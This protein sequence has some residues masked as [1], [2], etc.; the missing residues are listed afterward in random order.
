[1]DREGELRRAGW[2]LVGSATRAHPGWIALSVVTSLIWTGTK[3]T[4]PLLT[5]G[6]IDNGII[7]GD[8]GELTKYVALIIAVGSF[9]AIISALRRTAT[10]RLS[11]RVETELRH[12]LFA[13]LQRLHFAF[14][15]RA[16]T[17]QLMARANSDILQ[18]REFV[19]T[20]PFAAMSIMLILAIAGI[21]FATSV[22]LALLALCSLPVLNVVAMRFSRRMGPISF[23]L[24]QE[25]ADLSAVVEESLS[26]I[27]VV[28]GFGAEQL[29]VER[30]ETEA[31]SVREQALAASR[32]RAGLMP[33]I[34]FIPAI[35]L[36]MVLWYGGNLVL[37]GDL[38]LGTLVAFNTYILMSAWPLRMTGMIIV[39]ASRSATAAGRIQELLSTDPRIADPAKGR[40]VA[41]P[42]GGGEVRFDDVTFSY[43]DGAAVLDGLDLH[44][45]AGEAVALVGPTAS[46][47]STVARLVPRFY[48]A[49]GG[50][51]LLDGVD[52]RKLRLRD[53]RR[54]VGI[55]FE[56]TFL[57]SDTVRANIAFAD[58][59]AP[60]EAIERAAALAGAADFVEELPDGY[61]TLIGE[62]GFSLSGGQRQ[63]IA[64]ARAVLADPR[65]LIL[66]DATSAVDPTKEHEIRGA[67][68]EVMAGRTTIIIAHRPAT[69]ALADRVVLIDHGRV[70]A[71]GTH[72]D[73]V[74]TSAKYRDVLAHSDV[75]VLHRDEVTS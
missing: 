53:L 18:V 39:M 67:L 48:D 38:R 74:A 68:R 51:V 23:T 1:V 56:D 13:H 11:F 52:V 3:V 10:F 15:D 65:V 64:I 17:G 69:I 20:V 8:T 32:L 16:Q 61:D 33:I 45:R 9:Q 72:E 44:I 71:E 12:R 28:K 24:Q 25:L 14:H 35:A 5:A 75:P 4:I 41:L 19:M 29:Q 66:D 59:Q 21:M 6:A 7:D 42:G 54:A 62:H 22:P 49:E 46:G 31:D 30:L 43:H 34:D 36:V 47:K 73:L 40:G 50:R 37:D 2:R 27:R 26:G 70:V 55:V 58:P 63:R 60:M 57:F